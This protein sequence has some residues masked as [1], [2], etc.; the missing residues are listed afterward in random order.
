MQT[1]PELRPKY[2]NLSTQR[3][4]CTLIYL[5][6]GTPISTNFPFVPNGKLMALRC[7]NLKHSK[8]W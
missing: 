4:E 8:V 3:S 6:I 2:P 7:P 1:Y 5:S